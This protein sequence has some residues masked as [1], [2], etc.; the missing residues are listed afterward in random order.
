[1]SEKTHEAVKDPETGQVKLVPVAPKESK[2]V[3]AWFPDEEGYRGK[4]LEYDGQKFYVKQAKKSLLRQFA[5]VA[6]QE[7]PRLQR[8]IMTQQ[9]SEIKA[10]ESAAR[11]E[12]RA[13]GLNEDEQKAAVA[14]VALPQDRL[15]YYEAE[16]EKLSEKLEESYDHLLGETVI[17][18]DLPRPF[19]VELLLGF[20]IADKAEL[21]NLVGSRAVTGFAASKN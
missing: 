10:L 19:S 1:M 5:R 21:C 4:P 9:Q 11:E 17:G 12:A 16:A 20:D 18:W 14:L 3:R 15:D 6:Q 8:Q 2:P 13:S 7:I